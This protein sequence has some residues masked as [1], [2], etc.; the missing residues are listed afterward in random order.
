MH[1]HMHIHIHIHTAN[2]INSGK[3]KHIVKKKGCIGKSATM[4]TLINLNTLD[5]T[6][7]VPKIKYH[8]FTD[9]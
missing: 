7:N 8:I 4:N 2:C 5:W 1:M 3:P 6:K 9:C